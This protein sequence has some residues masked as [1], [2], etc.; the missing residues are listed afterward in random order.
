M[1]GTQ[2]N[3]WI[4]QFKKILIDN[5]K[6]FKRTILLTNLKNGCLTGKKSHCY[7]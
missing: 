3:I 6:K 4:A 2:N 7:L 5:S 1:N